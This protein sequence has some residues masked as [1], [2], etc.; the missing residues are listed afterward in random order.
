[1]DFGGVIW[2]RVQGSRTLLWIGAFR[3]RDNFMVGELNN[4]IYREGRLE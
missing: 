4:F 1:M 2:V 3:S